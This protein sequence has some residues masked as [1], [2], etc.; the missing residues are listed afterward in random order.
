MKS[1]YYLA[2]KSV[3]IETVDGKRIRNVGLSLNE[4]VKKHTLEDVMITLK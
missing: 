2:E 1:A 4:M 3:W